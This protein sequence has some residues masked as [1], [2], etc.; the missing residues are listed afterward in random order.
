MSLAGAPEDE[1]ASSDFVAADDSFTAEAICGE[2]Q[3]RHGCVEWSWSFVHVGKSTD[4][5]PRCLSHI[6]HLHRDLLGDIGP[7]PWEE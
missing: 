5:V 4:S 1:A 7:I 3:E 6:L 2:Y